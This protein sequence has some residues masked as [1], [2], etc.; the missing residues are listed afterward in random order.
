[1]G[2]LSNPHEKNR[3]A[4]IQ[5]R[6]SAAG[7]TDGLNPVFCL[8]YLASPF[9]VTDCERQEQA[10]FSVTLR[11]LSAMTWSQIRNSPRHGLGSEKIGRASIKAPIPRGITDDVDFIAIR[12]NG[13]AP[14]VG[15][16]SNQIF[17]IVWLD[18]VFTL[19]DH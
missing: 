11:R 13:L 18:R 6:D 10:A 19:Y 2:R 16:R 17:H 1:V 7:S 8:R 12:F 9:C 15:F 3:G 14:M 5:A 4:R